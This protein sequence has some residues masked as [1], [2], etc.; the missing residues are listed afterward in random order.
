MSNTRTWIKAFRL[1]T[2]PLAV[3]SIAMGGF[4]ASAA[5]AFRWD[6]FLLC[7]LTTIFLQILSNL[8][9]DYG[10]SIHGADS[11]DR[12][13]P[14][15]AVQSGA[16]TMAQMR[17]AVIVFVLLSLS[18]GVT[19]LL[20]S[21]GLAWK[22]IL[23]FFGLGVLSIIAAMAYTMGKKPYGYAGLGDLSVLIFFG[24]VGVLGSYYL[25]TKNVTT[26]SLL[27]ALSCGLFSIAVL[28]INNIRDIDSDRK[29]G[30]F[31]IPVRIGREKAVL[32]HWV[33]LIAGIS[34]AVVFT[35][36]TYT[37]AWQLLF[38]I[39]IP[40]FLIN[41]KAVSSKPSHELDP[42]LK[43]MAL[44]TLLFVLLFGV[45]MILS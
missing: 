8:A 7:I 2:L 42:Y 33:L 19:L 21:F 10:D 26:F 5:D 16:V 45:G 1:R 31:S 27:P 43:Q 32:Y 18:S 37:S 17:V 28:N 40:L 4:L 14:S 34:S 29:A 35:V 39:T 13:G 38:V 24:F 44:S 23:F 22:G 6:I 11:V 15:R 25:F 36:L 3:S 41:G 30:K 9:N 12:K 20:V